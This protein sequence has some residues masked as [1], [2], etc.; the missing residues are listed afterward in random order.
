MVTKN[1]MFNGWS[2]K[3]LD[4]GG[5]IAKKGGT[6]IISHTYVSLDELKE[7]LYWYD[8]KKEKAKKGGD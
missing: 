6:Q 8:H 3:K 1:I 4:A 5:Y 7:H 2:I